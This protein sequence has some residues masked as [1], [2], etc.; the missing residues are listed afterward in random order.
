[1]RDPKCLLVLGFLFATVLPSSFAKQV[2]VSE[3][4]E[5]AVAQSKLTVLGS[6]GTSFTVRASLG[7]D[8]K[9]LGIE[10]PNNVLMALF[11]PACNALEDWHFQPYVRDGKT[12]F[13]KADI[14]FQVH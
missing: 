5:R 7:L 12:D 6:S 13:Y 3:A 10:N 8:G 1:M 14:T 2:P 11:L 4:A 9:L